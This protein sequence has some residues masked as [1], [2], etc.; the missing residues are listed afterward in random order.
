MRLRRTEAGLRGGTGW[1]AA[2]WRD[3]RRANG[4]WLRTGAENRRRC[5][6]HHV[7]SRRSGEFCAPAVVPADFGLL[8]TDSSVIY[9]AMLD[10]GAPKFRRRKADRPAEIVSAA[11]AVFAE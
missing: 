8:L 2:G 4:S 5:Q 9:T 6:I 10:P 11:M 3:T 1:N 7:T